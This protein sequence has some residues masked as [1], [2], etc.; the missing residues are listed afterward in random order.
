MSLLQILIRYYDFD[1]NRVE[2]PGD[3][4]DA[5]KNRF[6]KTEGILGGSSQDFL[7]SLLESN[8]FGTS[9]F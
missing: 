5:R 2:V 3:P 9:R 1:D 4:S 7:T 6:P 8:F